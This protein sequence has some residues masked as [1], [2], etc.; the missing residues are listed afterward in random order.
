MN[1]FLCLLFYFGD[2]E[3]YP[4]RDINLNTDD[5]EF[6]SS[7]SQQASLLDGTGLKD[8]SSTPMLR[9][10]LKYLGTTTV[11][12][13]STSK[14]LCP[15][16]VGGTRW[17][18]EDD[19]VSPDEVPFGSKWYVVM[20][21]ST[22]YCTAIKKRNCPLLPEPNS[23]IMLPTDVK[24]HCRTTDDNSCEVF[25]NRTWHRI[26][27]SRS[28][29][30]KSRKEVD[31]EMLESTT[32]TVDTTSEILE[33]TSTDFYEGQQSNDENMPLRDKVMIDLLL[34]T[35]D[36]MKS[37][38]DAP[39]S[40]LKAPFG[41][42]NDDFDLIKATAQPRHDKYWWAQ[43][44][45][46]ATLFCAPEEGEKCPEIKGSK[47][48][49]KQEVKPPKNVGFETFLYGFPIQ[50]Q[51]DI[52][53]Q[54]PNISETSIWLP[55]VESG[56][57]KSSSEIWE[58]PIGSATIYCKKANRRKC[59]IIKRLGGKS[60][61]R[62]EKYRPEIHGVSNTKFRMVLDGTPVLCSAPEIDQ[63][64][65]LSK[66]STWNKRLVEK[67]TISDREST[68][69]KEP[70][71]EPMLSRE[72]RR[73]ERQKKNDEDKKMISD[74]DSTAEEADSTS[75][76][77]VWETDIGTAKIYCDEPSKTRCP[78]I[79]GMGG[80]S[81]WRPKQYKSKT[82]RVPNAQFRMV[83]D[84]T[85][86]LCSAPEI[87]QCPILSKGSMWNRRFVEKK[88]ISG[89]GSTNEK[90]PKDSKS[91]VEMW[92]M[93]IGNATIYCNGTNRRQCPEIKDARGASSWRS[94]RYKPGTQGVPN[95]EFRTVLD[96][97]PV[98]CSAPEIEQC[99]KLSKE[100]KWRRRDKTVEATTDSEPTSNNIITRNL[101]TLELKKQVKEV[102]IEMK[103]IG[104][105]T[106]YCRSSKHKKSCQK[107]MSSAKPGSWYFGENEDPYY[108]SEFVTLVE[109]GKIICQ[110]R[111]IIHC[112]TIS[113]SNEWLPSN[114]R[115]KVPIT[116]PQE[117][118]WMIGVR[119]AT[120]YCNFLDK[121]KCPKIEGIFGDG[122]WFSTRRIPTF[123]TVVKGTFFLCHAVAIELCPMLTSETSWYLIR[124][125]SG[126]NRSE[127]SLKKDMNHIS[128]AGTENWTPSLNA[129]VLLSNR[130]R[131]IVGDY[132]LK[133]VD[134]VMK[135]VKLVEQDAKMYCLGR[136]HQ[137]CPAVKDGDWV[138]LGNKHS[139]QSR[140]YRLF[141]KGLNITCHGQ[142][143]YV[144][145]PRAK[146]L[147]DHVADDKADYGPRHTPS[148]SQK[149]D[150]IPH[151]KR[152]I[153]HRPQKMRRWVKQNGQIR[154]YCDAVTSKNCPVLGVRLS[155]MEVNLTAKVPNNTRWIK[156][157]TDSTLYCVAQHL[158]LCH[159]WSPGRWESFRDTR[160]GTPS[161]S[162]GK[163]EEK[164]I[165][166]S[167]N[168][169]GYNNFANH[170]GRER[171][172]L[173]FIKG[174]TVYCYS[175][176]VNEC[177]GLRKGSS[178]MELQNTNDLPVS[179]KWVSPLASSTVYCDAKTATKCPLLHQG[180]VIRHWIKIPFEN[181]INSDVL[182]TTEQGE[183]LTPHYRDYKQTRKPSTNNKT[184]LP[185][186]HHYTRRWMKQ[187][188]NVHVY[189][190]SFSFEHCQ[191]MHGGSDWKEVKHTHK[192]PLKAEW[193]VIL[194]SSTMY[195]DATDVMRCPRIHGNSNWVKIW[196][197]AQKRNGLVIPAGKSMDFEKGFERREGKWVNHIGD[198]EFY[199]ESH[200]QSDCPTIEGAGGWAPKA[201]IGCE[202][203]QPVQ[204]TNMTDRHQ[205]VK[206]CAE[207]H[208]EIVWLPV[209][210]GDVI[211]VSLWK[212]D[213]KTRLSC[214]PKYEILGNA[215]PHGRNVRDFT[216]CHGEMLH[217][218]PVD[219]VE[220]L[221]IVESMTRK[222]W[223]N[224]VRKTKFYCSSSHVKKC[225]KLDIGGVWKRV[226][227]T[228]KEVGKW[229]MDLGD[230]TVTCAAKNVKRCMEG[231]DTGIWDS[232]MQYKSDDSNDQQNV[233]SLKVSSDVT[234]IKNFVVRFS[235]NTGNIRV[236][237]DAAGVDECPQGFGKWVREGIFSIDDVPGGA[238]WFRIHGNS[239]MYCTGLSSEDCPKFLG[240]TDWEVVHSYVLSRWKKRLGDIVIYCDAIDLQ[241][242]CPKIPN[243]KWKHVKTVV[244][245]DAAPP[246]S[247]WVAAAGFAT[248]Y[249]T[250]ELTRCNDI[251]KTDWNNIFSAQNTT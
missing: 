223:V 161:H 143:L 63:C 110:A 132:A 157:S 52:A 162:S 40:P 73:D 159:Q 47:E 200:N 190:D 19:W 83:L 124:K 114:N 95:A 142:C 213:E 150:H 112:P 29:D 109:N 92:V 153:Q 80:A 39:N 46:G 9:R 160:N 211:T 122:D 248:I 172:W 22:A 237:C 251:V 35:N 155:W 139:I 204:D 131:K 44:L 98:L 180:N 60:S 249:C 216:F 151:H 36:N 174:V 149:K 235:I 99:P 177:P 21:N 119:D 82:Q 17:E 241:F 113:N 201:E 16:V 106:V 61:W 148:H 130:G 77:K 176:D 147:N 242:D 8:V 140:W 11:F 56:D 229:Q 219:S 194:R 146:T 123:G 173:S 74:Y 182:T 184:S 170:L 91:N 163:L 228:T 158:F 88:T 250:S 81:S 186:E 244:P 206:L 108:A 79:R 165:K 198:I 210:P 51:A 97:T 45:E 69:E 197:H 102:G 220:D 192:P 57:V 230:A 59:P 12:C 231:I 50:C 104:A 116:I 191:I 127:R 166:E 62:S 4:L 14:S 3:S 84:G 6:G 181:Y 218:H 68:N 23:W 117:S 34:N 202:S 18:L 203:A 64:P 175:T 136:N 217:K 167:S 15:T 227:N 196:K 183:P 89:S 234:E 118:N 1:I 133:A 205:L 101:D 193:S 226:K 243:G 93:E 42:Q 195:C 134:E 115:N 87:D 105:A 76:L 208:G 28:S 70:S 20:N 232:V 221:K 13:T 164:N 239:I 72:S 141:W 37:I 43:K 25:N 2:T 30:V 185:A 55:K 125:R 135:K 152:N 222:M 137:E 154:I 120:V 94:E 107:I 58:L 168:K 224:N 188:E 169:Q 144:L 86:V 10:Y 103:K 156:L 96:G 31:T 67:K 33:T 128:E 90:E 54:C 187:K 214:T 245:R 24:I 65:I 75:D 225:P 247:L 236:F 38:T 189:C 138:L 126:R 129:E 111:A 238:K 66:G 121:R 7:L 246:D 49:W 207:L 179:V 171:R 85:P 78:K 53:D 240:N 199:C 209:T 41:E 233:D 5:S 27:K 48:G 32:S 26:G 145:D 212:P 178:W 215:L 71:E 100:S